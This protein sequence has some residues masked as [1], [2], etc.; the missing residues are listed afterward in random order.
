M[1]LC[2]KCAGTFTE[3]P[4]LNPCRCISGYP[5]G[6]EPDLSEREAALTQAR[7]ELD[8]LKLYVEQGRRPDD[9]CVQVAIDRLRLAWATYIKLPS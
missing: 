1:I 2:H 8:W 5:R 9:G 6:F 3:T 4:G 7:R